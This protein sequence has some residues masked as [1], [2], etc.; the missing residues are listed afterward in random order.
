MRASRLLLAGVL[1]AAG[2]AGGLLLGLVTGAVALD[3]GVGRRTRPLGPITVT[4]WA[5]RSR[6]FT[7]AAAP[8]AERQSRA[9]RDKVQ[10][11]ERSGEMI[12]AAHRTPLG[13][14]LT[15]VTVESV[16]LAPPEQIRFRLLRGP[17]PYVEETF[18]LT[19]AD[20]M[21]TLTY[22]GT[23]ATD[24]WAVGRWWGDVVAG[25]WDSAVRASLDQIKAECERTAGQ[26]RA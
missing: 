2:T 18:T 8:Y 7:A 21:T 14:G 10:I 23:L 25:A 13:A 16:V 24:L 11:L 3:I 1:G 6:V 9:M 26:Y 20:G 22:A 4:I 17:V 15:A 19:E 5:P 12:V